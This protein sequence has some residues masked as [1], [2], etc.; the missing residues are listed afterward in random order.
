MR[1]TF[2]KVKITGVLVLRSLVDEGLVDVRNNTASSN[3]TFDQRVELLISPDSQLEMPRRD[4]LHLQIFARIACKLKN[5]SSQILENRG[6]VNSSS[7]PNSAISSTPSLQVP[8][9]PTHRKL[10]FPNMEN[11]V[12]MLIGLNTG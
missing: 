8:V 3:G 12:I 7:R 11:K 5:L 4:S 1:R 10:Q 9:N 6:Q 2:Q